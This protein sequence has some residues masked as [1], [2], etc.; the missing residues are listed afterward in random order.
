M[1]RT[2]PEP[3]PLKAGDVEAVAA[4]ERAV[5]ADPWSR[6]SF[7]EMLG[8]EHVR[9]FVLPA[10]GGG[11]H[12]YAVCSAA[13]DEGEILNVAVAPE[14]R[15]GGC[16]RVLLGACLA[17]LAERGVA[18]VYLE[19]RRSNAAAI[20]MYAGLGFEVSGV[21]S[22]YYRMPTEDA[23]TMAREVAPAAAGK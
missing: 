18:R 12:G 21:R 1:A 13:A 19:V 7:E 6:R 14:R 20:A 23:I 16:G 2:A 15:R 3:R 5:F 10:A 11:V 17:W 4:L 9:A 8:L 22:R